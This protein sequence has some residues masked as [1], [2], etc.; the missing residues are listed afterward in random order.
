MI[1]QFH[2]SADRAMKTQR[3]MSSRV[4]CVADKPVRGA[5]MVARCEVCRLAVMEEPML[6]SVV[7]RSAGRNGRV[8]EGLVSVR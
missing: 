8:C 1:S 7:L 3:I 5:A 6:D 2:W 4:R